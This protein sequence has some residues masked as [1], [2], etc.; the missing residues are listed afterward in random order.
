M[1]R[2]RC[3]LFLCIAAACASKA[4]TDPIP[5][6]AL[7][8]AG[9][10]Q[11]ESLCQGPLTKTDRRMGQNVDVP[12]EYL[13]LET[14]LMELECRRGLNAKGFSLDLNMFR[15]EKSQQVFALTMSFSVP[16]EAS[17]AS[18]TDL[19]L[20]RA[21]DPWLKVMSPAKLREAFERA[22]RGQSQHLY[23]PQWRVAIAGPAL[24]DGH[25]I[26]FTADLLPP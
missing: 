22:A 25:V 6:G 3:Y 16:D 19:V 8:I 26:A 14:D 1:L 2:S 15:D 9:V 17:R 13:Y 21:V 20:S 10:H 11:I 23:G 5:F 4:G 18:V 24:P 12:A 7:G